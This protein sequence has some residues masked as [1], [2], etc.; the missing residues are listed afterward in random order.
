MEITLPIV[1]G[2][3][4]EA[5]GFDSFVAGFITS[6]TADQK[7]STACIDVEGRLRY[8]PAFVKEHVK[9]R[10]ALFCLVMHELLHPFFRHYAYGG[11][12]LVDLACDA[13]INAVV[14]QV[15]YRQSDDGCLF[16]DYYQGE[17][18][19]MILR[20]CQSIR[21][22]RYARLHASLYGSIEIGNSRRLTS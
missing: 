8:G 12:K 1:R 14:S 9:T 4:R 20:P 19:E 16:R 18:I 17:G 2:L 5:L 21:N 15:F 13:V 7:V 11:G 10:E 22:S 6:V 3:L